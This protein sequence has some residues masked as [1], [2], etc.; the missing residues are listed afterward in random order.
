[1]LTEPRI[2]VTMEEYRLNA[3]SRTRKQGQTTTACPCPHPHWEAMASAI[4]GNVRDL[5]RHL[6]GDGGK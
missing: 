6:S 2:V 3:H 5:S 4:P 1:M